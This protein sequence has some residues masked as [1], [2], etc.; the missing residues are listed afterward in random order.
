MS[1]FLKPYIC[2]QCGGQVDRVTLTCTMC[3]TQFKEEN[4]TIK[5]MFYK[6]GVHVLGASRIIDNEML[7]Y[8]G[9]EKT[10]EI[11]MDDVVKELAK[12]IAPFVDVRQED[13]PATMQKV[14][15]ARI[16]VLDRTFT[17]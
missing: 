7:R 1:N 4:D 8:L 3:G 17:F 12:C 5:V 16:R 11:V 13:M 15:R 10:A 6:P 2:T 14:V 9:A